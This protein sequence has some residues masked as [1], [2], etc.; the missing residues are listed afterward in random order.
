MATERQSGALAEA[1]MI[2]LTL[3]SKRN[4]HQAGMAPIKSGY[5]SCRFPRPED[6]LMKI[7]LQL[8]IKKVGQMILD[9]DYIFC[10]QCGV[11]IEES[12]STSVEVR[13]PC[14][15][16][17]STARTFNSHIQDTL[18]L[19]KKT[20]IKQKRAGHKKPIYEGILGEDLHRNSGQWNCLTREIDRE[21]DRY[22]EIIVDPKSGKIIRNINERL[23][24]HTNR[25][26]AK[27]RV[28]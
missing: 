9:D 27:P 19:Y 21:N 7:L 16:C 6:K 1:G 17:G 24:E 20:K 15:A 8:V 23:T 13:T 22:K 10:S 26:S 2:R 3:F 18:T 28:T 4:A 14:A 12:Q 25:N 5:S 11:C